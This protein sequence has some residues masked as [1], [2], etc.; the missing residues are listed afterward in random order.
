MTEQ[1]SSAP[2]SNQ[3][4]SAALVVDH[5]SKTYPVPF[6]RLKKMFGRKFKP[7]VEA[8]KDVSFEVREGE[9]FG[10]I[11]PN[12]AGKTTLTKMIAT[13]IQPTSGQVTV[14][15]FD[16]VRD[17]EEVRRNV[18]LAGA[19]ERSFYWRLNAEQN[20]LF[21]ARLY[22][23]SGKRARQRIAELLE[24]LQLGDLSRRRFAELSTGNKQRLA[25]ARAMLANPPVLLLDEPTRSLDPIAAVRMR[26]TI[27]SLTQ[28]EE[29]RVTVF[30]TSHNLAE[31]EELCDR[32][33]V[34]GHGEIRA[35][36][37]PRN[38]RTT[39][40][41]SERV[42]ISFTAPDAM[43][44]ESALRA[45]FSIQC[46][47]LERGASSDAWMLKFSRKNEDDML[48]RALRVLQKSNCVIRGI[49]SERA[50]LL[51]VLE[52][53]EAKETAEQEEGK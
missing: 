48:D 26:A 12:G 34:I 24:L 8:V 33:A 18:G 15:G 46:L 3:D 38:L 52:S 31:V 40:T 43:E 29:R 2:S 22:G 17:D 20:L 37:S 21:F 27:K 10:L 35:L 25:V 51:D 47:T 30:L 19:E 1:P 9:I 32:V 5:I 4:R 45:A 7:P 16:S 39:H 28:N 53:Y 14:K 11:G 44:V 23:L 42:S 49:D 13:L 36:D 6:L 41:E 50:T